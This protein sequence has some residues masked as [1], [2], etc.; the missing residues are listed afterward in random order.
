MF[1][2]PVGCAF[3]FISAAIAYFRPKSSHS[4]G[5][6]RLLSLFYPIVTLVLNPMIYSLENKH[7]IAALRQLLLKI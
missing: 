7:V 4:A 2:S 6:D 1:V 5:T 3:I